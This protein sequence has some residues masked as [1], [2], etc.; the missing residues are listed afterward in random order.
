MTLSH[1]I[2]CI[3]EEFLPALHHKYV[4]LN[5]K[6]SE[7]YR[8]YKP[9]IVPYFLQGRPKATILHCLHRQAKSNT[10]TENKIHD[11]NTDE[12]KFEV[13]GKATT[14]IVD[15]GIS[16]G[17]PACTC[18]D[19][20]KNKIPCKHFFAVFKFRP[21]WSWDRLPKSYLESPYL[22][23]DEDAINHYVQL[24]SESDSHI[25]EPSQGQAVPS[26]D[27]CVPP[28]QTEMIDEQPLESKTK[29]NQIPTK[30]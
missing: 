26:P 10:F 18:K 12:G 4:Y 5:F 13:M 9:S 2:T 6:Q 3:T 16:A 15:F 17:E 19:W 8:S 11:L 25:P 1:I 20:T 14:H 21:K 22:S 24:E 28:Q 23:L 29:V 7:L 27:E 30:V